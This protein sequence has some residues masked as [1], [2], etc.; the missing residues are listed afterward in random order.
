MGMIKD[1]WDILFPPRTPLKDVS[2]VYKDI[3]E[4]LKAELK[5]KNEKIDQYKKKHPDNGSE[6]TEW[7]ESETEHYRRE[8]ELVNQNRE[9]RE[10]IIF[11]EADLK[12]LQKKKG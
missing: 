11:L 5:E 8:I 6:L 9:L 1:V 3:I 2:Q 10:R 12:R 4:V 7:Q